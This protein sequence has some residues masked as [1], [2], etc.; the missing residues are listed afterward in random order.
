MLHTECAAL[1]LEFTGQAVSTLMG[2]S[3]VANSAAV[4]LTLAFL[5]VGGVSTVLVD[6]L[7]LGTPAPQLEA[8]W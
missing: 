6:Y 3:S 5:P 7:L 4:F 2:L 8:S 1:L